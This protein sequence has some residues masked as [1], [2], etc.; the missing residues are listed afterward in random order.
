MFIIITHFP[1]IPWVF[2][3]RITLTYTELVIPEA[4]EPLLEHILFKLRTRLL[5]RFLLK[6][7][8]QIQALDYIGNA[9]AA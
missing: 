2:V 1:H 9:L 8:F 4:G 5:I 6:E 3:T 7:I